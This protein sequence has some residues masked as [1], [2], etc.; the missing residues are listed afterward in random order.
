VLVGDRGM[1]KQAPIDQDDLRPVGFD[2][3]TALQGLVTGGFQQ[4]SL[5]DDRDMA[6]VT[7]PAVT[8]L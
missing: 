1:I 6:A 8:T 2:W 5:F 3:I 4:M 7:S